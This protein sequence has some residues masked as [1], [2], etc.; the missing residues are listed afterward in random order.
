MHSLSDP[1]LCSVDRI[2]YIEE[3]LHLKILATFLELFAVIRQRGLQQIFP[4]DVTGAVAG[5]PEVKLQ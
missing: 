1:S 5:L 3:V 4:S 2:Q